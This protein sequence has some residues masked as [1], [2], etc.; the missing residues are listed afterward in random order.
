MGGVGGRWGVAIETCRLHNGTFPHLIGPEAALIGVCGPHQS[1]GDDKDVPEFIPAPAPVRPCVT[2]DPSLQAPPPIPH[3][4][5]LPTHAPAPDDYRA[6]VTRG[7][8]PCWAP[9]G[10]VVCRAFQPHPPDSMPSSVKRAGVRGAQTT[11]P[12]RSCWKEEEGRGCRWGGG[13]A[14]CMAEGVCVC[15]CV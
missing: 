3:P 7:S 13:G 10:P 1:A 5:P 4:Q 2:P 8:G 11:P 9:V 12:R 6:S 15:V 14:A